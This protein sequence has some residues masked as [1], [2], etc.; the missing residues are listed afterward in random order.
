M[1]RAERAKQIGRDPMRPDGSYDFMIPIWLGGSSDGV[2]VAQGLIQFGALVKHQMADK[3]KKKTLQEARCSLGWNGWESHR[4][5]AAPYSI[6]TLRFVSGFKKH[7]V[8]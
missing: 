3:S 1:I 8:N 4:S 7:E 6:R 2:L 5:P